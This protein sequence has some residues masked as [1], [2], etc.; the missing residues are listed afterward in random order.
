MVSGVGVEV[1][2]FRSDRRDRVSSMV[3]Y[4]SITTAISCVQ[5]LVL[6]P[7]AGRSIAAFHLHG[8]RDGAEHSLRSRMLVD[9][10]D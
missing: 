10:L 5:E 6:I 8:V 9:D 2:R 1:S 4:E 7:V 3:R